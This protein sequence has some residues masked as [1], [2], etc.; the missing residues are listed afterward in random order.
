M[1]SE[2]VKGA[3]EGRDW[4][5]EELITCRFKVGIALTQSSGKAQ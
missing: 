4:Q 1:M 2:T 5:W 3:T